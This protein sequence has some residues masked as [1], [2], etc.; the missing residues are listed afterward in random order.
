[1]GAAEFE[2]A[3]FGIAPRISVDRVCSTHCRRSRYSLSA[4]RAAMDFC[5]VTL[6]LLAMGAA[7]PRQTRIVAFSDAGAN[8]LSFYLVHMLVCPLL[9]PYPY[10][11]C[12]VL[13][14]H[15]PR[16]LSHVRITQSETL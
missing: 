7:V 16:Y 12:S 14:P 15:N 5:R 1:M 2:P 8:A 11:T 4:R 13:N 6:L 9:H 10:V 3:P